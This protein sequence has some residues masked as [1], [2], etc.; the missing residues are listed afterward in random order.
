MYEIFCLNHFRHIFLDK[1]YEP[2]IGGFGNALMFND[3]EIDNDSIILDLKFI[4]IFIYRLI[5][6]KIIFF[7]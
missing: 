4:L 5:L 1:N 3:K 2:I 6:N 7:L